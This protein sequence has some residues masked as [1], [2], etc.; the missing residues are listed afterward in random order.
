[1]LERS[2]LRG[3]GGASFPVGRKWRAVAGGRLRRAVVVANGS[4]SEPASAKDAL[5]LGRVPHL[6]LDGLALAAEAV[7]AAKAV[8]HAPRGLCRDLA[9]AVSERAN[10]G[11]DRLPVEVVGASGGFVAGEESAVVSRLNGGPGGRPTFTRL[12]PVYLEGVGG[13]PTLVQNVETLA[14]VALISRFGASWFR[15]LGTRSCPGSALLTITSPEGAQ[16]VVEVALGTPFDAV[17]GSVGIAPGEVAGALLGGYG[18]TWLHAGALSRLALSED[19]A[20]KVGATLGAG[21]VVT[22]GKAACPLD[23]VAQITSYMASQSAGQCG[24]CRLGLPALAAATNA[25]AY[26]PSSQ[27]RDA[28]SVLE[29]CDLVDGRGACHHPDGVARMVRS[30]LRA[31]GSHVEL[32][33]RKGPCRAAAASGNGG[34]DAGRRT[35]HYLEA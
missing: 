27:R 11:I 33:L 5:L 10:A 26:A 30:A 31:F 7:G 12:R 24:P 17:A 19:Q 13:R 28:G 16:Q 2:G 6:V 22:M 9:A 15:E 34:P 20:R 18:G 3:R 14:H 29:L 32:H 35:V 21:V 1:V 23:E 4:D 8:L 25:L